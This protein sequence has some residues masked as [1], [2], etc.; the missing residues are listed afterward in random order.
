MAAVVIFVCSVLPH[1]A[2]QPAP[3]PLVTGLIAARKDAYVS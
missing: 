2:T 3:A 1:V